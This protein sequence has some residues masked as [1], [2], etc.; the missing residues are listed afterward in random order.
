MLMKK[1]LCF[2]SALLLAMA[3]VTTTACSND[4][5]SI[6][7]D[8]EKSPSEFFATNFPQEKDGEGTN[9]KDVSFAGFDNQENVCLVVNSYEELKSIYWGKESLPEIDFSKNSLII[10]R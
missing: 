1:I 2:F 3:A 8:A 5:E 7:I 6:P 10:G 9:I 4:E